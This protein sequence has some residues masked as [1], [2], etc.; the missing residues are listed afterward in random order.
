MKLSYSPV[1]EK[2]I[3]LYTDSFVIA[4]LMCQNYGTDRLIKRACRRGRE[5]GES[6]RKKRGDGLRRVIFL[7]KCRF[8]RPKSNS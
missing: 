8:F 1:Y 6:G 4:S 5:G 7:L 3:R 2:F